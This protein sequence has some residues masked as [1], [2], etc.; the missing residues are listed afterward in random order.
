MRRVNTSPAAPLTNLPKI[1]GF[2]VDVEGEKALLAAGVEVVWRRGNGDE[3]LNWA[4]ASFREEPGILKITDSL[5]IF[6][7][8]RNEILARL[9]EL[10][11]KKIALV[12]IRS[13]D[14]TVHD[15]EAEALR[16]LSANNGMRDRRTAKKRG[17]MGGHAKAIAAQAVRQSIAADFVLERIVQDDRIPWPVKLWVIDY[18]ISRSSLNRHYGAQK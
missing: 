12:D 11:R 10:A 9:S 14:A 1:R 13:P 17:R 4:I 16:S 7:E 15:L 3:S 2:C 5:L 8:G 18:K 6:G